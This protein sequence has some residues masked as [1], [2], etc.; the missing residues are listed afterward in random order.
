MHLGPFAE[1]IDLD[2]IQEPARHTDIVIEA[3]QSGPRGGVMNEAP[4]S[5][6][7]FRKRVRFPRDRRRGGGRLRPRPYVTSVLATCLFACLLLGPAVLAD[8][9]QPA[10]IMA[11]CKAGEGRTEVIRGWLLT[12]PSFH[13]IVIPARTYGQV[14]SHDVW[15]MIRIYF[16]R[17]F[18]E[19]T[20][21]DFVLLAS[22]DMQFFTHTQIQWMYDAIAEHGL[23]GMNT[24][25]VQSMSIAWSGSWMNSILSDAFPN[26][27]P[28]VVNSRY[29]QGEVFASGPIVVN[30][31]PGLPAVARPFSEQIES[32]F[33]AYR[34]V[35]TVP[36]PGSTIHTWIR[37]DVIHL[38]DPLP[39]Y[40]PHL[41]EWSYENA[42][43]FTAMDM[44][45][46]DFWKSDRN[47]FS[48]D[49][50]GNVVWRSTGRSLP[51]DAMRVH[52]LRG[53]FHNFQLRKS[54]LVSMFEFAEDFGAN[55]M[56]VYSDL[57]GIEEAK[58][59]ADHQ[60]LRGDFEA[61]YDRMDSLLEDLGGLEKEAVNLKNR[62]LAWVYFVEWLAVSGTMLICGVALWQLMVKRGMYREVGVT[63]HR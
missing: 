42:T 10:K 50:I 45:C 15:K 11:A 1:L 35:L 23:G 48:L 46:E 56:D 14:G 40:I 8:S 55:T 25:S 51:E 32:M 30:D 26:D 28:A 24:R 58:A 20:G 52:A 18:E 60:Y 5:R 4:K 47:P 54:V 17:T 61:S 34:G 13:G 59:E 21:Y 19:L 62:A 37:S 2:L 6:C 29:Y 57:G 43:T 31:D 3:S 22:V 12:E 39:G 16:P 41:F 33:P 38:G 49:I 9:S 63:R 36:R 53:L 44:V 7:V 27:V